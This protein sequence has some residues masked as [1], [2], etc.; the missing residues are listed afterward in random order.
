MKAKQFITPVERD[1]LATMDSET[2]YL[3][4]AANGK[5]SFEL[6]IETFFERRG[7]KWVPG[8]GDGKKSKDDPVVFVNQRFPLT[9]LEVVRWLVANL[10]P[11]EM[12]KDFRPV[13]HPKGGGR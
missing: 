6:E 7:R 8:G 5:E 12:H 3:S 4:R 9:R 11:E 13:T 2:V 1:L 10:I